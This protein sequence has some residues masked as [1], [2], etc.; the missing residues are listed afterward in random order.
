ML[1]ACEGCLVLSLV[2]SFV[3]EVRG[4][5]PPHFTALLSATLQ[6][7]KLGC[8][9]KKLAADKNYLLLYCKSYTKSC[10]VYSV[11]DL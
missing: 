3:M 5:I 9:T 10:F 4:S 11:K 8:Q 6:T 2:G 7:K 1:A